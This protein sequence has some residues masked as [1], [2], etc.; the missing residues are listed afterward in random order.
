[1]KEKKLK[2]YVV[3]VKEYVVEMPR[4]K[5]ITIGGIVGGII[6]FA[7]IVTVLLN[8][9][10]SG[11]TVLYSNIDSSESASVYQTLKE[12]GAAPVMNEQGEIMVPEQE[13]D[14]WLLKLAEKGFPRSAP[15]Y[16]IFSSHVGMT[17]TEAE[18]QQW[19]LYQLQ[20][21]VQTT[22]KRI[23]GVD[24]AIVT[25]NVPENSEY[26][27]EQATNTQ[28]A[29]ASV[30]L[31]LQSGKTL[32]AGQITAVKNLIAA[33]VPQ[34]K[35]ED[36]TVV[37]AKTSLELL[38]ES[39]ENGITVTQ[40]LEFEKTVQKQ[41]EDNIV[42]ALAPR[43]GNDGV[44]AVAKV[45]LNYDKMITEK[46]ELQEKPEEQGGGGYATHTEGKYTL[47][48]A[49]T[50][51]GIAGEEDNTDIP[52][53]SYTQP[54]Q[55]GDTTYYEWNTDLDYSYIK[56]Q[57]EKGGAVL[58]RATVSVMVDE[59]NLTQARRDELVR[60]VSN[61]ADI[62][63]ELV[64]VSSFDASQTEQLQ[65]DDGDQSERESVW[66]LIPRWLYFVIGGS[67]LLIIILIIAVIV[68][69]RRAKRAREKEAARREEEERRRLQQEIESHKR[70][71]SDAAKSKSS[72]SDDAVMQEVR[73]FA[74]TNPE[75]TANLLRSWL[76]E[77][78]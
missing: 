61:S 16:D 58:E 3:H 40:N 27:W 31:T 11:Y 33:S 57:V 35:P 65:P 18:R 63:P 64:F 4:K 45:T 73:D 37:D 7:V 19:L 32:Q 21:R 36:V 56:T 39:E 48:G 22:L 71:L 2:D 24:N 52:T 55:D 41:I 26:V 9:N 15:S 68:I 76:K 75:I 30:L 13:Y 69:R 5:K 17:T 53:Y 42:R 62:V 34:M 10:Q 12:M 25:I 66:V 72:P 60:L 44:V 78:Q 14:I 20:D 77:D 1:M 23:D 47:N 67:L 8:R 74:K 59:K 38:G 70:Q 51:G 43:Y 49:E 29:T 28:T 54:A 6:L 50:V 46:K